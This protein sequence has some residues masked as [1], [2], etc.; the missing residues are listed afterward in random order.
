MKQTFLQFLAEARRNPE[1]NPKISINQQIDDYAGDDPKNAYISFTTIDKLGINPGSTYE[2]PLGIY[3]YPVDYVQ[4][5]TEG[6]QWMRTLPFAGKSEFATLFRPNGNIVELNDMSPADARG[7][8]K[9]LADLWVEISGEDW[10]TSVDQVEDIINDASNKA[11][12]PDYIGGRF[13]YVVREIAHRIANKRGGKVTMIW[14]KLFRTIGID[15]C[16]DRGL[17]II[18]SNEPNQAVFFSIGAIS[19]TKRVYNKWSPEAVEIGQQSGNINKLRQKEVTEL[20]KDKSIDD[21]LR[22][23]GDQHLIDTDIDH[24]KRSTIRLGVLRRLPRLVLKINR[25]TVDDQATAIG[26]QPDLMRPLARGGKLIDQA[27]TK[28]IQSASDNLVTQIIG[29]VG[30]STIHLSK[31]QFTPSLDLYKTILQ[32]NP[33]IIDVISTYRTI[34]PEIIKLAL[35]KFRGQKLPSWL[36]VAAHQHN[37][38]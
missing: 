11:L 19:D 2:T 22:M 23:F 7:Y 32:I 16:V 6:G 26:V 21:V 37:L 30:T 38:I 31:V 36:V 8:Y 10:K 33:E 4:K 28:A 18:H 25:P 35:D 15:G 34:P 27:I 14:N 24:I 17:G 9:K 12:F 5:E 3:A 20:I 29:N 13:W 1:Q